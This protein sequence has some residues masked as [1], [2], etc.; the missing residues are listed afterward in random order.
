M[1]RTGGSMRKEKFLVGMIAMVSP[2]VP[3]RNSAKENASSP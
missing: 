2:G 3:R 1:G